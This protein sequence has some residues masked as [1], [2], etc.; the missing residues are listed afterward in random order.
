MQFENDLTGNGSTNVIDMLPML[1]GTLVAVSSNVA[2]GIWRS[3]ANIQPRIYVLSI[4]T[5]A[6]EFRQC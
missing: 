3:A 5:T 2:Y 4:L 6:S 1:A